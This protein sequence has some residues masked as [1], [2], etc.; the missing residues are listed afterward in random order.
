M[1]VKLNPYQVLESELTNDQ[2]KII[3]RTNGGKF[4]NAL[5]VIMLPKDGNKYADRVFERVVLNA[6]L[7]RVNCS[8]K[9]K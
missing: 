5:A 3:L 2:L 6:F 1:K 9:R 8:K 4:L 7:L